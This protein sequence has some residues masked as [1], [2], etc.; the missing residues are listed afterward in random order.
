MRKKPSRTRQR[1]VTRRYRVLAEQA[2]S[3]SMERS[4][5]FQV[6]IAGYP[7]TV[8]LRPTHSDPSDQRTHGGGLVHLEFTYDEKDL[9]RAASHGMHLVENVLA[10]LGVV[11]GVPFGTAKLIQI[12]DLTSKNTTRFLCAVIPKYRHWDQPVTEDQLLSLQGMLAHWDGLEKGA[13]I[14]RA[15]TLYHRALQELE[16][17]L[18]AFQYGYMGLEALEPLLAER[19]S[20]EPGVEKSTG[21]CEKCGFEYEKRRTA[22]NG[23]RAYITGSDHSERKETREHEWKAVNDLRNDLFHS[24]QDLHV[25]SSNA[26]DALPAVAH[27]LHDAICCLSHAHDLEA[28]TFELR[29]GGRRVVFVGTSKPGIDDSIEECRLLVDSQKVVWRCHAEHQWVPEVRFVN[30]RS[31][32][33]IS[34]RVSWLPV[35]LESG[36]EADLEPLRFETG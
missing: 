20:V 18:A 30:S 21:R 24:L 2:Y 16:D 8:F 6:T 22:L 27:F 26:R 3:V 33:N 36:S 34:G 32:L 10:G 15:A 29:R 4:T 14:R 11:G 17:D 5:T 7:C 12:L 9:L 25:L 35:S 31:A 13:R 1:V 28:P 23:V 19:Q